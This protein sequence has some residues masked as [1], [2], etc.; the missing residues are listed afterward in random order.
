MA[1]IHGTSGALT[2]LLKV[3]G[4]ERISSLASVLEF[5][6]TFE[7]EKAKLNADGRATIE[8]QISDAN[9]EYLKIIEAISRIE[10]ETETAGRVSKFIRSIRKFFAKRTSNNLKT[11]IQAAE[12]NIEQSIRDHVQNRLSRIER[13]WSILQEHKFYIYGAIGEEKTIGE[14]AKLSD[15]YV[16]IND[17]R[18]RFQR[19]IY[20]RREDDRIY[21]VQADHLV[22]GPTGLFIIETKN[23]SRNSIEKADLLSP[24]QQVKR[25]AFALFV[26]LNDAVNRCAIRRFKSNWGNKKI[27]PRQIVV[28]MNRVPHADFQFVKVLNVSNLTVNIASRAIE[29]SPLEVDEISRFLLERNE[30]ARPLTP[31]PAA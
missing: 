8:R 23:W 25:V 26:Y 27:S 13:I 7:S 3:V 22:I 24:V 2:D 29:L 19:P 5:G 9:A 12:S 4:D 28:S 17:F 21:S 30:Q 1:R 18:K 15:E 16:V 31:P 6:K 20:N 14:L 10:S 11:R